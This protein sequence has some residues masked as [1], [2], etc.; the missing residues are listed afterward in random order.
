MPSLSG[1]DR[2]TLLP[3]LCVF[4]NV[5]LFSFSVYADVREGMCFIVGGGMAHTINRNL[6]TIIQKKN[7]ILVMV[8]V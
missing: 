8:T 6:K 3:P 2:S 5:C 7:V 1:G 4:W